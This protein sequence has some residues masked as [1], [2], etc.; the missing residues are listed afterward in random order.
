MA[1][2]APSKKGA[3]A[4]YIGV[5]APWHPFAKNPIRCVSEKNLTATTESPDGEKCFQSYLINLCNYYSSDYDMC[6]A[7][8]IHRTGNGLFFMPENLEV[9][10][11]VRT[12]ADESR[13]LFLW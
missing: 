5:W 4:L 12:F 8:V 9:S 11:K 7:F 13:Q 10:E 3:N 6:L 2:V 1:P